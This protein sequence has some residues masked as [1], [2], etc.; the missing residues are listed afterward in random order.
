MPFRITGIHFCVSFFAELE[1]SLKE[2]EMESKKIS[3][4]K[5]DLEFAESEKAS[6]MKDLEKQ[7]KTINTQC[8]Q[9]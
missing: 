3:E 7:L 9:G 5:R 8:G 2:K 1:S 6:K 4:L